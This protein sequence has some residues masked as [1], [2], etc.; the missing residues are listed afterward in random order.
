MLI[1]LL[2]AV[3]LSAMPGWPDDVL[4]P[5]LIL[6]IGITVFALCHRRDMR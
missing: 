4:W 1:V 2:G 6:F 3:G 5:A